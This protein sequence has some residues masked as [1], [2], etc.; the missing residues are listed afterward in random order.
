MWETIPITYWNFASLEAMVTTYPHLQDF[1]N[2]LPVQGLC[3][4]N[5]TPTRLDEQVADVGDYATPMPHLQDLM[6]KS[7]VWGTMQHQC[8]TYKT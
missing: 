8:H 6:N 7:P 2:K 3:N 4:T 5:A 1:M